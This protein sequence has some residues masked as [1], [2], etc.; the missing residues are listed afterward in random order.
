M[1]VGG[2]DHAKFEWI[3]AKFLISIQSQLQGRSSVFVRE[4]FVLVLLEHR[5]IGPV[6]G[7]EVRELVVWR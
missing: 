5:Q 7:L 1:G 4:K 2:T 6:P 3:D